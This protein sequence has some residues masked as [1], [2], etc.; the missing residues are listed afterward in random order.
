MNAED[1]RSW[2]WTVQPDDATTSESIAAVRYLMLN[3]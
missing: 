1:E 2:M 3:D